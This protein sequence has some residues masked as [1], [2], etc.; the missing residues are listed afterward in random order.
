MEIKK[1]VKVTVIKVYQNRRKIKKQLNTRQLVNKKNMSNTKGNGM[2]MNHIL[3]VN[4]Q[5]YT[6]K[7]PYEYCLRI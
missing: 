7:Y 5:D 4:T 1:V 3:S 6:R 2:Q